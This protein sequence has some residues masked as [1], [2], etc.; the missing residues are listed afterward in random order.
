MGVTVLILFLQA[1]IV[2]QPALYQN[3]IV[4]NDFLLSK[5]ILFFQLLENF[6]ANTVKS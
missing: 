4:K 5:T 2:E 3:Q 6:I 1:T